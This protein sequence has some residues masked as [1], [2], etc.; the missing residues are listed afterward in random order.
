[1]SVLTAPTPDGLAAGI[2][3]ALADPAAARQ[4][5]ERARLLA[6]TK[7]SYEAYL[8]RTR[9]AVDRLAGAAQVPAPPEA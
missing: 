7:Y 3:A 6:E 4:L 5:G 2:L 8:A 9:E 1:M